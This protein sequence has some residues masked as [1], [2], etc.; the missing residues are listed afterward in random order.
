MGKL[1]AKMLLTLLCGVIL[2]FALLLGVY[3]LPV[4]PM[5][6]HVRVS[7]PAL[8][9]E[10]QLEG[11]YEAVI[12]GYQATQLDNSTDAAMLLHAVYEGDE[13]LTVKAAEGYRYVSEGNAFIAL[14]EYEKHGSELQAN[15]IARYWHGYLVLLKPLLL[16][17]NYLDIRMLLTIM[18]GCMMAAVI[19]GLCRRRLSWMVPAFVLSLLCITPSAAGLSL[20]FSTVFCTYLLAMILLLYL[21]ARIF[22]GHGLAMFFLLTGML[23]SYVDYLTYPLAA[24]GMP[25]VLCIFLFPVSGLREEWKRLILCGLC[26]G[27]GYLGMWAGKWLI[28]GIFG[29]ESWFWANLLAKISERSSDTAA[30]VSLSYGTVLRTVLGVFFKRAYLL[31]AVLGAVLWLCAFLRGRR[32]GLPAGFPCAGVFTALAAVALLP[33]VWYFFTQNHSYIHAF[34][35][36]KNLTVS[37][38]AVCCLF[39]SFLPK[40]LYKPE[41]L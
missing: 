13:P 31:A 36:S 1:P 23:T 14:L 16:F 32:S 37:V 12:A 5:A 10:W 25:M 20:Q 21:P 7:V 39:C 41:K 3:A 35:T 28:A 11:S 6:E 19:A 27:F 4:E 2:G 22:D 40:N 24:F 34:Y 38:F 30:A 9:G 29:N 17:L 15:P 33:F 8:S 18:Q 26:W